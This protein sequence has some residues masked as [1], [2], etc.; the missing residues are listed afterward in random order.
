MGQDERTPNFAAQERDRIEEELAELRS[1]R[2]QMRAELQG[3]ADTVGDRGDAADAL[4]RSEDLAGIDEQINRLTW[5]LAGGNADAPGQLPNGTEVTVRFPGDEPVRMRIIHFL[6]ETPAG[7]EDTTLTSDS[8]LGLALFG[9]RAG[10]TVT[11]STPRGEL[12]VELLA[13]DI[14]NE[15]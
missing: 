3:D 11:Y 10:E 7:E 13:I 8:P 9:R 2:D 5:L 14:P 1:R 6:E 12:Q 15:R 4:Q